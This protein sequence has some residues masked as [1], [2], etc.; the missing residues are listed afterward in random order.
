MAN[1]ERFTTDELRQI[2]TKI[3][4]AQEQSM[5]LELEIFYTIRSTISSMMPRLQAT[6]G[7]LK[8]LDAIL[9]LSRVARE[10]SFVRPVLCEDGSLTIRDGR[11]P[12]VEKMLAAGTFV[13]NDTVMNLEDQRMQIITGPNMAGKSTYMRQ[14]ALIVLMA[15]MGSFVPASEAVIP[16]VDNVFTRVGA[17]DDLAGGQSTFMV[18]MSETAYILRNATEK[19]LVILDEIGRGTSTYDGMA[20]AQSMLEF[21]DVT[22]GAKTMFSTHYHELTSL[23]NSMDGIKNKHVDVYEEDDKITFLY[24]VKDGKA[25]KSYGI[26]VASLAKLPQPVID[27]A[28]EL[29]K[30][31]EES[32]KHRNDQT[33]MVMVETVPKHLKEIEELLNQVQPDNMTPI[34]ALQ[35]VDMLKKKNTK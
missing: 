19:S 13:P 32:K 17:S 23:E 16:L 10:N 4:G 6:A 30:V 25:N 18:E 2:E 12:I 8:T 24:K 7:A 9:S 28:G 26:H 14:V 20:L 1:A 3:T 11:H 35:F 21:I 5:R 34:E 33:Q 31:F 15:H 29:L 22:I 27:R